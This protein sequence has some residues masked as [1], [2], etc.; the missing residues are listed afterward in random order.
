MHLVVK[1]DPQP[2]GLRE[3]TITKLN[4]N[5]PMGIHICGG[6]SSPPAN[7]LDKADEGIFVEKVCEFST[8][9]EK[10]LIILVNF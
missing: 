1:H 8:L 10:F 7:P 5:E 9:N 4:A 2:S 6:V 3:I